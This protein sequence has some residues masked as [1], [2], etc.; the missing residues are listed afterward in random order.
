MPKRPQPPLA[1]GDPVFN[2]PTPTPDPT[3]F[4]NPV[5]DKNDVGVNSVQPVPLPANDPVE[6]ILTLAQVYGSQGAAKTAAIQSSG[7]IVFR[8]KRGQ[9]LDRQA[10]YD[11]EMEIRRQLGLR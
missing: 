9:G 1:T 7:Q 5:T 2:Q 6:P 10:A 3:G 8:T 11:L 4:K